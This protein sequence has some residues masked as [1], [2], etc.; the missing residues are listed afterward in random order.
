MLSCMRKILRFL[1]QLRIRRMLMAPIILVGFGACFYSSPASAAVSPQPAFY[2]YQAPGGAATAGKRVIALTFDDGP[3]VYTPQ[4]LSVLEH[5]HVPA[6]FFEIGANVVTYPQ[7]T[8]MLAQAGY[9]VENHTWSHPNLTTI[10]I[11]EFPLQIDQTQNVIR[12]ITG[13]APN[14]VRPPYDVFNATVL[15]QMAARGL[16]TMSYSIDPRDWTNPGVQTIVERVVSAA[17]PGAVVDMHDGGAR[18][19]TVAALPQIITA[20]ES[21]GYSFVSICGPASAAPQGPVQSAVYAFGQ[22]PA[23]GP[24]VISNQPLVG[25]AATP[26]SSGYWLTASD[27]GVFSFG[28]ANFQGSLGSVRL[29]RPVVG[30][31]ADPA[32]GGY[33][34]AASDGGVFSF[35][36]SFYGST[37]GVRL[38]QP[39]VGMASTPDGRGYWLVAADGGVFSFGDAMFYGSTGGVKLS[40]PV[41]GMASTPDGRGYWLVAADGGVFSFGDAMFYGS[42]GGV[43]LSQPVVGMTADPAT[44]GYWLVARDGGVFTF[45]APFYGSAAGS[46]NSFVGMTDTGHGTG[47]LLGGQHPAE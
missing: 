40:Q 43:K 33:W 30:I 27:G 41:L 20:L 35:N 21:E 12:S 18:A 3:G 34:L 5:Y 31:V 1:Q 24:E 16:T 32:T 47:Y 39:V 28:H 42:T 26:D 44:G 45:H 22:A 46:A 19:E 2:T 29:N 14:C 13:Q 9:P 25:V 23:P 8:G 37:G 36:S 6:T 38:E 15:Q 11:S 10:P 7:Y 4:V 17:F